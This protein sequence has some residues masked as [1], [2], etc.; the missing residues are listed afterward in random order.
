MTSVVCL[1]LL[2]SKM[3]G[4]KLWRPSC[5]YVLLGSQF[6]NENITDYFIDSTNPDVEIKISLICKAGLKIKS[7]IKSHWHFGG[8]FGFISYRKLL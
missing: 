3:Q 8:H 7:N 4:K 5:I 2:T 6:V 1:S